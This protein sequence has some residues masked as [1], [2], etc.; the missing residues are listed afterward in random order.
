MAASS[1]DDHQWERDLPTTVEAISQLSPLDFETIEEAIREVLSLPIGYVTVEAVIG[2]LDRAINASARSVNSTLLLAMITIEDEGGSLDDDDE[3]SNLSEEAALAL[4]RLR[5]LFARQLNDALRAATAPRD[6]QSIQVRR[7]LSID[8]AGGTRPR[9][10]I[11]ISRFDQEVLE[12][13]LDPASVIRLV[14]RLLSHIHDAP[15]AFVEA[16]DVED[17]AHLV[18]SVEAVR[19]RLSRTEES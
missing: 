6:W 2:G 12:L 4:E 9:F 17:V 18:E 15:A 16:L 11:R 1:S 19:V 5:R 8:K 14:D 3:L 13:E 10:G 7:L